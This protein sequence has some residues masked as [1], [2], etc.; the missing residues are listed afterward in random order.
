LAFR[1]SA[2]SMT[3]ILGALLIEVTPV[4]VDAALDPLKRR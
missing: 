1:A 3:V 4:S 2:K